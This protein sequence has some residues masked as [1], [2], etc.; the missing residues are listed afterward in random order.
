MVR[1]PDW[2][3]LGAVPHLDARVPIARPD[4]SALARG[5]LEADVIGL[6]QQY[7]E[8]ADYSGLPQR[9]DA[10]LQKLAQQHAETIDDP[11]MRQRF[12]ADAAQFNAG[13]RAW[14]DQHA[15]VIGKDAQKAY[16]DQAGQNFIK[17]AG[18]TADDAAHQR[19][20]EAMDAALARAEHL[21][22][23]DREEAMLRRAAFTDQ[24][25]SVDTQSQI[26]RAIAAGDAE[27]L[28]QIV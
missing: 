11:S 15:F 26:D 24:F 8:D 14:A 20:I 23:L 21:G 7:A 17:A 10:D 28:D 2:Q 16:L 5:N 9:F 13:H 3:D 12:L 22:V 19:M 1:L 4:A 27:K 6:K 25:L 18:S